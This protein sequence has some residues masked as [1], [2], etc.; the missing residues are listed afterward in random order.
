[1]QDH[2]LTITDLLLGAA[3]A[4]KRL[5]GNETAKIRS[6]LAKL[7]GSATFPAA[8]EARFK[9][10]SPAAFDVEKAGAHLAGLDGDRRKVLEMIAAVSES[11]E[12]ID[13]SEDRYLRQAAEAMGLAAKDFRDLV[14][15]FQE[16]DELEGILADTLGL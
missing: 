10:F 9:D 2:I 6:L 15:D 1:M 13:L 7:L 11:D 4:D 16:V 12:E 8:V 3:Y 14:V 5:E